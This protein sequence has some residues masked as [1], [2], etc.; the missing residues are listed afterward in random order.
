M[1]APAWISVAQDEMGVE[2]VAGSESNPRVMEYFA[3][4]GGTWVTD[5]ATP[6]C[7]AFAGYCMATAG[8]PLPKEPLRARSWLS[9]GRALDEPVHGCIAVLKRGNDPTKGHVG[10]FM[11]KGKKGTIYLLAGNHSSPSGG[12]VSIQKFKESDVLG[13]RWADSSAPLPKPKQSRIVESG[14]ATAAQG[15]ILSAGGVGAGVVSSGPSPVAPPPP[16]IPS[17]PDIPQLSEWSYFAQ[18][19]KDFA[20]FAV[21]QWVWIGVAVGVYLIFTGHLAKAARQDDALSG[22]TWEDA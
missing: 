17:P 21:D 7:G 19:L 4:S 6:W 16:S 22:K 2:E 1:S 14:D 12:R 9:W 18:T 15:A 13:Y 10:F 3:T 5:D 20:T 8:Q 11:Q